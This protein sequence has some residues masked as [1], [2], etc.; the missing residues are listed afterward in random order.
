MP[1]P[2]EETAIT[3]PRAPG[4]A[5]D[6]AQSVPMADAGEESPAWLTKADWLLLGLLVVLSFVI[7]ASPAVN[8][9]VW[10]QLATGRLIAHGDYLPGGAEPFSVAT[11][12]RDGHAAVPWINHSWL[13]ALG[14]YAL[15]SVFGPIGVVVAKALL[16]A[17]LTVVLIQVRN[18]DTNLLV[19]A[20]CLTLSVLALATTRLFLQPLLVSYLMLALTLLVLHRAGVFNVGTADAE[21]SP[22]HERWLWAL[23]ALFVLWVNLDNW[24][25]LGPLTVGLCWAGLAMERWRGFA[26]R[27]PVGR[28]GLVFGVSLLACL[29]S[30]YHLRVFQLPPELAY[31]VV[32]AGDAV[33]LDL[34]NAIVGGGRAVAQVH[35]TARDAQRIDWL[36]LSPLAEGYLS[37]PQVGYNICGV[38]FFPLLILGLASFTIAGIVASKPGA[39]APPAPRFLVWLVFALFAALLYRLIPFFAI[40]AGP[41]TA[42]NFG[43]LL[44]WYAKPSAAGQPPTP[45]VAP[46]RLIR[47][48]GVPLMVA[49][50]LLSWP[51]WLN[52]PFDLDSPRHVRWDIPVDTSLRSAAERLAELSAQAGH[53]EPGSAARVFSTGMEMNA[54]CAWFAPGVKGFLDPRYNLFPDVVK[55]YFQA[56]AALADRSRPASDWSAVLRDYRMDCVAAEKF[57]TGRQ[58]VGLWDEPARWRQD[59]A[60]RNVAV[61]T[62]SGPKPHWPTDAV[63]AGWNAEAFGTVPAAQRPPAKG[64]AVPPE[65]RSLLDRYLLPAPHLP[66]AALEMDARTSYGAFVVTKAPELANR[67]QALSTYALACLPLTPGACAGPDRLALSCGMAAAA[68]SMPSAQLRPELRDGFA[69]G[70]WVTMDAQPPAVPIL[71]MRHAWQAVAEVPEFERCYVILANAAARAKQ[72]EGYW[73]NPRGAP[74]TTLRSMLRQVQL[75]S[76]LQAAVQVGFS[77]A[78]LQ[79]Q[80][81]LDLYGLYM[82]EYALDLALEQLKIA[83]AALDSAVLN[84]PRQQEERRNMKKGIEA[85]LKGLEEDVERRRKEFAAKTTR[86]NEQDKVGELLL[87]TRIRFT[88]D[89]KEVRDPGWGLTGLAL[90]I[91]QGIDPKKL[92]D[93]EK[94]P[95]VQLLIDRL[96]K[97]GYAQ[98]A[99]ELLDGVQDAL[100]PAALPLQVYRAGTQGNYDELRS[101]LAKLEQSVGVQ[102]KTARAVAAAMSAAVVMPPPPLCQPSTA[103]SGRLT[104]ETYAAGPLEG[105]RIKAGEYYNLMTLRGI[106]LLEAGDTAAAQRLF[107]QIVRETSGLRFTEQPIAERYAAMLAATRKP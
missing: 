90:Q 95:H 18:R 65:N 87:G 33:G 54:Y 47:L 102:M 3:L 68:A 39:P 70:F 107:D 58:H 25:V 24:F 67:M 75:L 84:D 79:Y 5:T 48:L 72:Q 6:A 103:L 37:N 51:G 81:H 16:I 105:W 50:G 76:A 80:V 59:F 85:R 83:E 56:Q 32:R 64:P 49:L 69:H 29:V 94:L 77:D 35:E 78:W 55:E 1:A 86:R 21:E 10:M 63:V 36:T 88:K 7:G 42:L 100:G 38:C 9:D 106:V 60:D 92:D 82:D 104:L 93:K 40:V 11:E 43:E 31:L 46:A 73:V 8:A 44:A 15:Y 41:I 97:V 14:L 57:M 71:A 74:P 13:F 96:Y 4:A 99:S 98:Q 45:W 53:H 101:V 52:G 91:L 20:I 26:I 34:P 12:A 27:V 19:L 61:F 89:N 66:E 17:V 22:R 23:P 28:L 30:P 62:W 2:P